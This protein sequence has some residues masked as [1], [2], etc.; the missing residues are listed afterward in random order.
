MEETDLVAQETDLVAQETT[1]VAQETKER[2]PHTW[3]H[4]VGLSGTHPEH[5][6]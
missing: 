5:T 6:P 4:T 2:K 1:L 3:T